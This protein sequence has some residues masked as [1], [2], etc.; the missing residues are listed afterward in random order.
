MSRVTALLTSDH[1]RVT[2]ARA[3]ARA[4]RTADVSHVGGG[5]ALGRRE[6]ARDRAVPVALGEHDERTRVRRVG[7][8]GRD[9]PLAARAHPARADADAGASR[10]A[11]S[12]LHYATIRLQNVARRRV[13]F[14]AS[15]RAR[16]WCRRSRA[17]NGS[18]RGLRLNRGVA[19]FCRTASR[20]LA[21]TDGTG[22]DGTGRDGTGAQHTKLARGFDSWMTFASGLCA[23]EAAAADTAR[24]AKRDSTMAVIARWRSNWMCV[25]KSRRCIALRYMTA[26]ARRATPRPRAATA[27]RGHCRGGGRRRW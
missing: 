1:S 26:P 2:A 3:R 17:S 8:D 13:G 6:P 27:A 22:R 18:A 14:H 15:V 5:R 25:R 16:V 12:A 24:Q 10:A 7:L 21:R 9:A 19:L 11:C 23:T 20:A 4:D